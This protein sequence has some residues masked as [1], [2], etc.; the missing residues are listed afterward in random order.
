MKIIIIRKR[1]VFK[2]LFTWQNLKQEWKCYQRSLGESIGICTF[3]GRKNIKPM[4]FD[5]KSVV[6]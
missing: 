5:V 2:D 3:S 1:S 6:A 4:S